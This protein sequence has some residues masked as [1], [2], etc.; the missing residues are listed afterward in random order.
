L[1]SRALDATGSATAT[2][3]VGPSRDLLAGVSTAQEQPPGGGPVAAVAAGLSKLAVNDTVDTVDTVDMAD[4]VDM[5]VVLACDMPLVDEAAVHRLVFELAAHADAD[6][7][8]YV[9]D[10][11][12]RQYLAAAYRRA[13][14]TAAIAAEG[15]PSGA[16]MRAVVARLT[17]TEIAAHPDL[18]LDCDTWPDVERT[19]QIMEDR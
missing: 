4:A 9:D 15:E 12:R 13:P 10:D 8:L 19:R 1:L 2:V 5:V 3:V 18:T 14:L 6:A 16:S 11:A 17:V 7:V